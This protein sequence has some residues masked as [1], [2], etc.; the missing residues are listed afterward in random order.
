[1]TTQKSYQEELSVSASLSG[2][3]DAA[4]VSG[5]FSASADYKK[6]EETNEASLRTMPPWHIHMH[7]HVHVLECCS[8]GVHGHWPQVNMSTA[9]VKRRSVPRHP[10][11]TRCIRACVCAC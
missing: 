7:G 9:F 6:T 1:M 11:P 4:F 5:S 3:F 10:H 2:G 8:A